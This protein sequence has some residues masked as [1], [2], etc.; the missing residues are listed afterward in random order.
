MQ[1]VL[2]RQPRFGRYRE[3]GAIAAFVLVLPI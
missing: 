2:L 1:R 3:G